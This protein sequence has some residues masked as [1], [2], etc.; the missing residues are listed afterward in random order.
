MN[1]VI[2]LPN[3]LEERVLTFPFLHVLI[4]ILKEKCEEDETLNVHIISLTDNI[5]VLNLLPFQA[6]YHEVESEDLKSIFSV[7]RSCMNLKIDKTD[8]FISTTDSFVDASIGKNLFAQKKI[9]FNHGKNNWFFTDKISRLEGRHFSEQIFELLSPFVEEMPKIP[10]TYSRELAPYY[11]DWSEFPYVVVNLNLLNGEINSEWE[12]FFQ[13]FNN[14]TFVLM[15]TDGGE[16]IQKELLTD[17]VLTLSDKNTYRI[18]EYSSSIDFGKI[19]SFSLCFISHDSPL[20]NIAS[21]CGASI[22]HLSTRT[23]LQ[24]RGPLYFVGDIRYFSKKDPLFSKEGDFNYSK[25]FDELYEY[26]EQ[27]MKAKIVE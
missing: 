22:F 16:N 2:K 11:A 5:D 23:D 27:R 10:T 17:Y 25:I 6:F 3:D 19:C 4:K 14:K 15:C 9:G 8:I 21:Y 26:I 18:F 1:I 13:L 12:N 20:I 24:T 7:H